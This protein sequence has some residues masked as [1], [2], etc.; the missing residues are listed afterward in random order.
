M[1]NNDM[2]IYTNKLQSCANELVILATKFDG[3]SIGDEAADFY[4][5]PCTI[6]EYIKAALVGSNCP[7]VTTPVYDVEEQEEVLAPQRNQGIL[8]DICDALE[9]ILDN[10]S[11]GN[12][13]L[14]RQLIRALKLCNCLAE[15][16][17]SINCIDRAKS[18]VGLLFC[19][20]VQLI[21]L[22]AA[23][24]VKIIILLLVCSDNNCGSNDKVNTA[25][26]DCLLCEL[27]KEL[28]QAEKLIDDLSDLAIKFI[29]FA[30]C[31]F[32]NKN[33]NENNNGCNC[34]C[35]CNEN[36]CDHEDKC[37]CEEDYRPSG[38][39]CKHCGNGYRPNYDDQCNRDPRYRY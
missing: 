25:F 11:I 22:I 15:T 14:R 21:L 12:C 2:N 7:M 19:L 6:W 13:E 27:K 24:I 17:R 26:C 23:I 28:D 30:K 3:Q 36:K 32:S 33:N 39:G 31:N 10:Y 29:K 37:N 8:D 38:N 1:N 20:L 9:Y 18:L 16:L 5:T 34:K 35:H 4:L